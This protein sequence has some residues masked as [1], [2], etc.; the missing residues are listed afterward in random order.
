MAPL[1]NMS[2]VKNTSEDELSF[3]LGTKEVREN[4][5]VKIDLFG[6]G[7]KIGPTI[8]LIGSRFCEEVWTKGVRHRSLLQVTNPM[9][10]T[11]TA[12]HSPGAKL[13]SGSSHLGGNQ[14][15]LVLERLYIGTAM[16]YLIT[17]TVP[18]LITLIFT[19]RISRDP[20]VF[21]SDYLNTVK[22]WFNC[23]LQCS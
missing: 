13:E 7:K 11:E 22:N 8:D 1:L 20:F 17:L 15:G 2:R 23:K 21:R 4:F 18:K 10:V 9:P 14:F 3:N 19:S 16:L 12:V 6:G 5:C